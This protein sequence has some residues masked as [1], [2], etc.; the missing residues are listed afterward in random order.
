MRL[1][2][3]GWLFCE[4]SLIGCAKS[5]P[6]ILT[7]DEATSARTHFERHL[8][9]IGAT[10]IGIPHTGLKMNGSMEIMGQSGKNLFSIE[11][12][13]PNMY[14][15]RISLAGIGVFERG[16]DGEQLWERTPRESRL[17]S[18]DE[19]VNLEATL[20]FQRWKNHKQWYPSI[21]QVFEVDFGGELCT[22]L[23]VQTHHGHNETLFFAKQS[24]LLMGIEKSDDSSII[25]YGQ[26]LSQ[27]DIKM[28]T[29]WEEKNDDVH[30]IWRVE[31]LEWDRVEVDFRPP[32]SLMERR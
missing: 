16:Y 19:M 32:P 15:I 24:G 31:Q 1:L 11:Q 7:V 30:K 10:S 2:L 14:Y 21:L 4:V 5:A 20:D 23:K 25:R 22:A 17:L 9:A 3:L 8:S 18:K 29:Y 13:M 28:P 26:Y 6:P 27:G 12:K